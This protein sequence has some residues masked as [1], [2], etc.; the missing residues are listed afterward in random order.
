MTAC[1]CRVENRGPRNPNEFAGTTVMD[2][3]VVHCPRHAEAHVAALEQSIGLYKAM[4]QDA[5]EALTHT[6]ERV[7]ALE[8]ERD[9]YKE[10]AETCCKPA[11]ARVAALEQQLIQL[12]SRHPKCPSHTIRAGSCGWCR[13]QEVEAEVERVMTALQKYGKHDADC[14]C[15]IPGTIRPS[16]KCTC[17]LL[18]DLT[19]RP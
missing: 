16:G 15:L 10:I 5:K 13:V 17:G 4:L 9:E 19:P 7:V 2:L 1:E 18:T 11:L 6:H 8:K 3:W 12:P 14:D